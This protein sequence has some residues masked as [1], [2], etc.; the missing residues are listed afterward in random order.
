MRVTFFGHRDTPHSVEVALRSALVAL[1]DDGADD[2][3]VGSE[4]NLDSMAKRILQGLKG[5]Y[6]H[7]SLTVVLAY[8]PEKNTPFSFADGIET[9]YP[10]G[11]ELVPRRFAIV[12]RNEW[13][14]RKA[15]VVVTYVR[16]NI[17]GAARFK[18][19]AERKGKR[20]I[21]LAE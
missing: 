7:I 4:G 10:E 16:G 9:V 8:L 13:L 12:R 17:G 20:V 3:F 11:L 1:I 18:A 19:L 6:P 5:R 21:N 15:D 2:F 14:V